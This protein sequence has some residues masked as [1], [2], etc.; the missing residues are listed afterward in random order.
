[1]GQLIGRDV[2]PI[3]IFGQFSSQLDGDGSSADFAEKGDHL[4]VDQTL[5]FP[6]I[7]GNNL[8]T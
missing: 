4:C 7:Y 6:S 3:P 1:L 2:E 8:I 5:N